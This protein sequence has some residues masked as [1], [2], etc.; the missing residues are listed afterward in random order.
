[1][2]PPSVGSLT[3]AE[4]K[5]RLDAGERLTL[6]DVREP[7][8]RDFCAIPAPARVRDLHLPLG[9]V[10]EQVESLRQA[11]APGVDPLVVYCHHG[12]RSLM[13]AR[14]LSAQGFAGVLNL[15]GG[16]DAYSLEADP[17]VPR[18]R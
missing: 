13:A 7:F 8:E 1:M 2:S 3:A 12:V 5:R 18:Y 9:L 10:G 14:W 4:L 15:D 17:G 16:I 6:L 11:V